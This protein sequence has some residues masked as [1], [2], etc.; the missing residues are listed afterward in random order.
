M[1]RPF[2]IVSVELRKTFLNHRGHGDTEESQRPLFSFK[3]P[4]ASSRDLMGR[5]LGKLLLALRDPTRIRQRQSN[6]REH[7]EHGGTAV[8]ETIPRRF[9]GNDLRSRR[10][11]KNHA[12]EDP[13]VQASV[14]SVFS[15]VRKDLPQFPVNGSTEIRSPSESL[16]SRAGTSSPAADAASSRPNRLRCGR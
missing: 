14:F 7:R 15:V 12:N 3:A 9:G 5:P 11:K 2:A 6:H 1:A 10:A 13:S 8:G 16:D 4:L